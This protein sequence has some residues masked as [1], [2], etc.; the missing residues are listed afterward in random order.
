MTADGK[1]ARK[2]TR[3]VL[4]RRLRLSPASRL[5]VSVFVVAGA[6]VCEVEGRQAAAGSAP[7]LGAKKD[8]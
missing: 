6:G 5:G 2:R 1:Q 4:A 7:G 3:T 8:S